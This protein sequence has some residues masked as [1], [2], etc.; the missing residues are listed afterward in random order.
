VELRAVQ[1]RDLSVDTGSGSVEID[2]TADIEQMSVDTGSGGITI[3]VPSTLG[4]ELVIDTGSGGIDVDVPLTVRR[5]ERRYLEGTLG[6]G[7]GR[8]RIET[9]SGGVRVRSS[10]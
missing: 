8:M 1:A 4:A 6:D 7:K 5:S 2:L 10:R 9:G 3:G